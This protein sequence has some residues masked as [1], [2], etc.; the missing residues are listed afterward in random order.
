MSVQRLDMRKAAQ[1]ADNPAPA[2][3]ERKD[4]IQQLARR[5][6]AALRLPPPACGCRDPGT[7]DHRLGRCRHGTAA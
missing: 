3:G 4:L 1:T 7:D 6:E 5:R 2:A